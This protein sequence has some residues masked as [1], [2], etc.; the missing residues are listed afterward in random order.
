MDHSLRI[1]CGAGSC[2]LTLFEGES[3]VFLLP[4]C[5]WEWGLGQVRC[6]KCGRMVFAL[7]V[8]DASDQDLG[9]PHLEE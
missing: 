3:S 8:P 1:V 9:S 7:P 4:Q 6:R 5:L 2:L